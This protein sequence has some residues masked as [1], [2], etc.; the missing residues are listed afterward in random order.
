MSR[1][2]SRIRKLE[3][4]R[5]RH[6]SELTIPND[7]VAFAE[8]L[9]ITPD[10]WQRDLLTTTDRRVILNCARQSGKSTIVAVHA[11]HHAMTIAESLVLI[12]SPTLRQSTELFRKVATFY[13]TLSGV[14]Y[15]ALSTTAL[16]LKNGSR[17]VSL[18]GSEATVRGYSAP[19]L[20]L[21]D[22]AA[23]VSDD[24]FHTVTPMFGTSQGQ[25]ILLSTPRGKAGVFWTAWNEESGWSK[26]T[27]TARDCPRIP[28]EFLE[29]ERRMMGAAWFAQEYC[30]EFVQPEG[31]PFNSGWVQYY[32]PDHLP[33]MD[34]VIQSWDTAL[35]KSSTSD[36]TVGQVWG[37]SG[38]DYYLLDQVRGKFDFDGM[39]A[40]IIALS[41]RRPQATAKVIEAQP[42]GTA[43]A[44]HLRHH[45]EGVIAVH[46]RES[47]ELRALNCLPLWQSG[48][49]YVPRPDNDRFAWVRDYVDELTTFP[50]AAHDDMVDAT[51]LAL[52]QFRGTLFHHARQ[53]ATATTEVAP[54]PNSYY[55]IGWVPAR[56]ESQGAILVLDEDINEVVLFERT[57]AHARKEQIARVH[58]VSK[59]YNG[60]YVRAFAGFD[61]AMLQAVMFKGVYVQRVEFTPQKWAAACENLSMMI[62]NGRISYPNDSDLIAELEVFK[63][64]PTFGGAP[65]YT[66]QIGQDTAIR[67]LCLVT[68]DQSAEEF[69]PWEIYYSYDDPNDDVWYY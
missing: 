69:E 54:S 48:N 30:C 63:S 13:R 2:N 45:V 35:T 53:C 66:Q 68:Y 31:S 50:N 64:D 3:R 32:D 43:L 12:L 25:L 47:K 6:T 36:Y 42:L 21:I 4:H 1:H 40:A 26:I 58:A 41:T 23:Q 16:E 18:P 57:V 52:N 51:T 67:A 49:V 39:V 9:G 5:T 11:L 56:A 8:L 44:S 60:A 7:P 46:V 27:V 17:I 10:P 38:A 37:R 28:K 61:E 29:Q 19:S 33:P 62:E 20:V 22:E 55:R 65:D 24:L 34:V 14:D 59:T 15:R